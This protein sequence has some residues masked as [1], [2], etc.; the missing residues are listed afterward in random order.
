MLKINHNV[1]LSKDSVVS[2]VKET[3]QKMGTNKKWTHTTFNRHKWKWTKN[4]EHKTT[5]NMDTHAIHIFIPTNHKH[6]Y[7]TFWHSQQTAYSDT[8]NKHIDTKNMSTFY[9]YIFI[10][11]L[12]IKILKWIKTAC[13]MTAGAPKQLVLPRRADYIVCGATYCLSAKA[14]FIHSQLCIRLVRRTWLCCRPIS[15]CMAHNWFVN[16]CSPYF[17]LSFPLWACHMTADT[18]NQFNHK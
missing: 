13:P 3:R 10:F 4:T 12:P 18:N 7:S 17:S 8:L 11:L 16:C 9:K 2:R 1:T 5:F 15:F 6:K 14:C